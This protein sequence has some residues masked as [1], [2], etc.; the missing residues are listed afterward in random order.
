MLSLQAALPILR[1]AL[2]AL[3]KQLPKLWPLLL[4]AKNR[5]KV[6]SLLRDLASASPKRKLAARMDL[7]ELLAQRLSEEA[8]SEPE[9]AQ[10]AEWR[11]RAQKLRARVD[12]PVEGSRARRAHRAA[13]HADL[14]SLH[15]EMNEA[16]R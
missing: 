10:A 14:Q 2:P 3:A 13:L 8:Q 9:R 5:E 7:T 4:E 11:S 12:M 6:M 1:R 16:L 15:R